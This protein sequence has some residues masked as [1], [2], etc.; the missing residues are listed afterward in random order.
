VVSSKGAEALQKFLDGM[1]YRIEHWTDAAP[2]LHDFLM[3]RMREK[4]DSAGSSEG[5]PWADYGAEPKYKAFKGAVLGDLTVLR[6]KGGD[7][8]LYPS[9]VSTR[10]PE[11]VFKVGQNKVEV[12]TA[13]PYAARIE[14]GGKNMFGEPAPAR[15]IVGLGDRSVLR[16]VQ[17][18]TVYVARGEARGNKW[19]T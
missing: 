18:L 14:R 19:S 7:E 1:A 17:L 3:V 8:R 12:G 13:V 10:H 4:Y 2:R 5:T 11:H 9:L 16:L 15:D 6:W